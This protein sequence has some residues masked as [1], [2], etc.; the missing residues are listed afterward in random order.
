MLKEQ[1][2][3]K[4]DGL[5]KKPLKAAM[6]TG[7]FIDSTFSNEQVW[8]EMGGKKIVALPRLELEDF[9]GC[10]VAIFFMKRK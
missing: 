7:K 1:I 10:K 2:N 4:V 9:W 6:S 5:A 8:R 3:I